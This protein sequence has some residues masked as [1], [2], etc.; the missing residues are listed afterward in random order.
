MPLMTQLYNGGVTSIYKVISV[1]ESK[2]YLF[3]CLSP[4]PHNPPPRR[5]APNTSTMNEKQLLLFHSLQIIYVN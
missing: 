4:P 3:R 2:F 1:Y 5:M